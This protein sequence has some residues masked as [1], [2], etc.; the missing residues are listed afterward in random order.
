MKRKLFVVIG[1]S[2][3]AIASAGCGGSD[4]ST[5]E[6]TDATPAGEWADGFCGAISTWTSELSDIRDGFTDLSS[7]SQ[8]G[9]ETAAEDLKTATDQL[10]E[11]IQAL[12]APDTESG[13][14]IETAVDDLGSTLETEL[15][16]IESTLDET[17]GITELPGAVQDLAASLS[18]MSSA[19]SSTLSSIGDVDV[20]GELEDAFESSSACD[21]ITG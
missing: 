2:V 16:S 20:Q 4:E 21:D 9:L 5:S 17:S 18:A 19:F 13:Q 8:D 10:I 7:L 15:D 11:D 1:I 12:G 6:T 3:L 14:E